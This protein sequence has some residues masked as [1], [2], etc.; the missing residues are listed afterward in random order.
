[1]YSIFDSDVNITNTSS[2]AVDYYWDFGDG[3]TS[4]GENPYHQFPFG[5]P[6]YYE[7]LLIATS[8]YGCQDSATK[9][10]EI[11]EE[12]LIYVPNTF[13]PDGDQYNNTFKPVIGIGVS[14]EGY[15]FEIYNRWGELIFVSHDPAGAWDGTYFG[16]YCQ[17]GTYTWKLAFVIS[18]DVIGGGEKKTYVGH[19]N[20]L[21]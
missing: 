3:E 12:L 6:G 9:T 8:Q 16:K 5:Q 17:D 2:G 1:M 7:I 11:R 10:I 4:E 21:R 20:I 14:P 18:D 13:T 19:V 15:V